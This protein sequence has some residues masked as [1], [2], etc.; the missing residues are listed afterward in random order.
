MRTLCDRHVRRRLLV[1]AVAVVAA[2]AAATLAHADNGQGASDSLRSLAGRIGD[3]D[4]HTVIAL[5][6]EAAK[7]LYRRRAVAGMKRSEKEE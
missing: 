4:L 3:F 1:A 2:V 5:L 6:A 7:E